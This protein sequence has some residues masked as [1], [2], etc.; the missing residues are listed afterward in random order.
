ML[1]RLLDSDPELFTYVREQ[2]DHGQQALVDLVQAAH[3]LHVLHTETLALQPLT[4]SEVIVES[5][6]GRMKDS[7][8]LR[9]LFL[10]LRKLNSSRLSNLSNRMIEMA[11]ETLRTILTE[12]LDELTTL[13]SEGASDAAPLRS[14]DDIGDSTLR[15]TVTAKKISLSKQKATL[16]K[17]D[18]AYSAVLLRFCN[19]LTDYFTTVLIDPKTL[20][21]HEIFLYDL[22]SP[23]RDVFTPKPRVA[24]E[25]ALS[26][27]QDYLNCS[28]CGL[29]RNGEEDGPTLSGSQPPTAVLY[30]LY[31][32]SGAVIN[33]ADLRAAFGAILEEEG[34]DA[35]VS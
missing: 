3:I 34:E 16:T 27:P 22:R 24:V 21:F 33:A 13:L 28:C 23:H 10:S 29:D 26:T 25:R 20:V 14:Q 19:A 12:L 30:Q 31:M 7:T 9:N 32:E 35:K 1:R 2:I 11:P 15:T 8:T 17:A 4:K 18:E 5:I 6:A